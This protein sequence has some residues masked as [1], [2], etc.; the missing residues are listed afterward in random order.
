MNAEEGDKCCDVTQESLLINGDQAGRL[1]TH[2]ILEMRERPQKKKKAE[3]NV[4]VS[5]PG[6]RQVASLSL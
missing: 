1:L 5:H 6:W 4:P 2:R 3:P